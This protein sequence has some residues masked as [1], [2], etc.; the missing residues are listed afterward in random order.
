MEQVKYAKI[1][2]ANNKG[3]EE[4][5]SI[6]CSSESEISSGS[7]LESD[8]FEEVTSSPPCSSSSGDDQRG[9]HDP[10]SNMSSLIQQLPIK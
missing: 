2:E 8:S 3:V 5:G 1:V 9:D 10:F 6:S 4:C 7:S